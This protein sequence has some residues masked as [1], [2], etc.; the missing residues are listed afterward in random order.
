M[1]CTTCGHE[2]PATNRFCGG[3]GA[4]LARVCPSC[5]H[6]NGPDHRFCGACGAALV[7]PPGGEA[8][9][10]KVVTIVFADLVGSTALHERLDPESVSRL[11]D[12]YHRAV[13]A[14]VEAHSGIVVQLLGDGVMCAFGVPH[15]AEDDAIRAVRAAVGIQQAFR[16]F[17]RAESDVVGKVGLRVGVNTGEVVV[18]DEYAA[19]IG[20]PLNVAARLQQEARDG[21]VLLGEATQR[22]VRELVTLEPFGIFALKGRAETVATFRVVSLDRPAGAPATPFVGRE[23]ELRRLMAVYEAA[24]ATR[25]ARL[26]VILGSPGLG[27]SRLMAEV[28]RRLGDGATVLAAHCEAAGGATFAPIARALRAHLRIADGAGGEGLRAAVVAAL[29]GD[30][31]ATPGIDAALPGD[32][33]AAPGNDAA[34]PREGADRARIADGIAALLAGTPASPEET[35]FVIRRFLG[36]LAA[37]EPVVLAIDDLHWAEPLLLDLTEHLIQWSTTVPLLVLAAARPELRETRSSLTTPGGLIAEVVTLAGLDAGAAT[38]LAANVIGAAELPAAVA[39]RVLATSEGNPLFVG[40]L[41]RMLVADGALKREGDRWTT[42]IELARLEMP[43]TIQ[44][45]L[46]A[47]IE[48][49]RPEERTVLERAAVVGRQFSRG[50]VTHLLPREITDLDVRL[51]ALKRSELIEPDTGW[52]LGEPAL[53]FHHV[54]VRDAAYRRL[55]KNTRAELHARFADWLE[56]RAGDTVEHDGTLGWHLEQ[57][58]QH[59]RELGPVDEHGRALGE[60]AARYLAAAGRRALARDDLPLA[61]SLLGR[62]IDRLD[63]TDPARADLA[64]D[65]CEALL[66]AGDVGPA[67]A[68]VDELRR[69]IWISENAEHPPRHARSTSDDASI[70]EKSSDGA[71]RFDA[72]RRSRGEGPD[73][74]SEPARDPD[75]LRAWHTCFAGELAAL[76]DPKALRATADA[77]A[78]A[79]GELAAAGDAAGEAKAYAV[80][81]L[82]LSRLGQVGASEAALDRALAAARRAHDRRRANAVLAG[83][84]IAAL[85]GPS[86]VTRASGR[87]LDVVRVLR[88][89]QGAPAVEA[90]ALRCQGV[91]EA[92]RGRTEAARRMIASSR[93]M[94]EELGL[95]QGLLETEMSAGLVELIEGDDAAAERSLRSAYEGF[96]DHGL[97]IDAARAAGLLGRTL[98]PQGRAAEAEALSHESETLAGDDLQAAITWRRVRAEALALR[99]EHAS[100]IELA[101][102]AVDIATA[103]DA[104]LHHADARLALAT[105]LRAAGRSAEADAEER[106]AIELWAAKG[107][108]LPA[109]RARPEPGRVEPAVVAPAEA[110]AAARPAGRRVRANAATA[111]VA[112]ED[113]AWATRDGDAI[114]TLFAA[115]VEIVDHPNGATH[116]RSEYLPSVSALLRAEAL[117]RR[118]EPVATL[119][120]AL[121]LCRLCL[122]AGGIARGDFDVSAYEAAR[123]VLIEIDTQGRYRRVEVF[124]ADKLG[125]AVARLYERYAELLPDGPE[126]AR[127]AATARSVAA[128]MGRRGR[129]SS[130]FAPDIEAVDH[131][132]VV[133]FGSARGVEAFIRTARTMSEFAEDIVMRDEDVVALRPDALLV[134]RTQAGTVRASGGIFERPLLHLFV[135]GSDGLVTRFEQFDVDGCTEAL[136]RFDEFTAE[137][138]AP[139]RVRRPVR[140]NAATANAARLDELIAARDAEALPMLLAEDYEVIDHTRGASYGRSGTLDHYRRLFRSQDLTYRHEPLAT[141]GDSLVLGRLTVSG[142]GAAGRTWDVGAFEFDNVELLEVDA[143]GRRNRHDVFAT[144][145]LGDAVARLYE[146]YAELLPDGPARIRTAATARTVADCGAVESGRFAASLSSTAAAVDHRT[147][148]TWSAQGKEAVLEHMRAMRALAEDIVFRDDDILGLRSDALLVSRTHRGTDRAGG[149]AYE[150]SYFMLLVFDA[151]GLA[152]RLEYFDA[153][154]DAEALARFDEVAAEPPAL[155][156]TPSRAAVKRERRVRANPATA[157]LARMEA[158]AEA[159]DADAFTVLVADDAEMIEHPTGATLGRQGILINLRSTLSARDL[160]Y[161]F[162]PLATLGDALALSRHSMSASGLAH[163]K[164]DVGAYEREEIGLTQVDSRGRCRLYESFAVDRLDDAVARLYERYAELVPEGP[165]RTRA[166]ATARSVAALLGPKDRHEA[167]LRQRGRSLLAPDV[168]ARDHRTVGFGLL[169]GVEALLSAILSLRELS[170]EIDERI[171]DVLDLRSDALL[172]RWTTSGTVR[173]SGG[174][175]ALDLCMLFVFGADG[176][177]TRWEQFDAEQD[178][179]ALARFDELVSGRSAAHPVPRR[180]RPNAATVHAARVDAAMATRDASALPTL[181][182]EGCEVM[183]HTTGVAYDARGALDSWRFLLDARE[184]THRYEPLAS[185]GDALALCRQSV[186]ARS[187]ATRKVDLGAYEI[188]KIALLEVDANGRLRRAEA[189]TA[190]RLGA[191]VARLYER[192]AEVL[193]DGPERTRAAATARSVAAMQGT[194]DLDRIATALAPSVE[195]ADYRILGTWAA[196]GK[197]ALL[198]HFRAVIELTENPALRDDDVLA[199]TSGAALVRRTHLGNDRTTG[200]RYERP[201]LVLQVFGADGLMSRWEHFDVDRDAEALARF[202]ELV[203]SPPDELSVAPPAPPFPNAATRTVDALVCCFE[204]RDW[205]AAVAKFAPTMRLIDRRRLTAL[206]LEGGEFLANIR[207]VYDLPGIR[208]DREVLATRG[209]RLALHR[210]RLRSDDGT[211]GFA[212]AEYVAIAEVDSAGY[213]ILSVAFELDDLD[214]AYAEIDARY[215]AGEAAPS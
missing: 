137:P 193:P 88:I 183:D 204:A 61:G 68:A 6:A 214:A 142:S 47:R 62:A 117:T 158:A 189:F 148:G 151:D 163:G 104:L 51:E 192:C 194:L 36:A 176:L 22:L 9:V 45:L 105:A 203:L 58:H 211:G 187:L 50:A 27:K 89:T 3:C 159:R 133:G 155:V 98:L 124:A 207:F 160:T 161:R 8:E 215:A 119:G 20:D 39:G 170:D 206:D 74:G 199:L 75:R 67:A 96:R 112:R 152:T 190:D 149:G 125:A 4:A 201:Y 144:D 37:A 54:L 24:V 17:A 121:A 140:A 110:I 34:A 28:A 114:A 138:P 99:G 150:R 118:H 146:R 81:A 212:D 32:D 43:P 188:E 90:V 132:S 10:R 111:S 46:A 209:E 65:W 77:V 87:C 76:T 84:P 49:L 108:T 200:G 53:R 78:A 18:S 166:T 213:Q 178:A 115:E 186:S 171:E 181:V 86:P 145:H 182:A 147:L 48:R 7:A 30:D 40:E 196:R 185:L 66:A 26:A 184:P 33:A 25:R 205:G 127:A 198:A 210:W 70:P 21:D 122:S 14:P 92:L 79:A 197:E 19:G 154:R 128:Q 143:E 165:E 41:V 135:F 174:A 23:A 208:W 83:A 80:H 73:E 15:V 168:E 35:F 95:T 59:L 202:D 103:T 42:G 134:R 195:S 180:V 16:E 131:R 175:F 93:R 136:A 123:W 101:R 162:E 71:E 179:E 169:R 69:C 5:A 156:A 85:W 116:D 139:H 44:A 106:R 72:A 12:R 102:A 120:G 153:D 1:K 167:H 126:R 97:G 129:P 172:A 63:A 31:A 164:F 107:A 11:M 56:A 94:V 109:E 191:A 55:L 157:H 13:R 177:V 64:L 29:R 91:L 52:F 38:R 141:L 113:T 60:R 57:A 100:A 82:A 173:A 130:A 2:N